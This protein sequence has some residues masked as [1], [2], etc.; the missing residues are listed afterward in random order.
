M[1]IQEK[2][3]KQ[4]QTTAQWYGSYK[5]L[6][7]TLKKKKCKVVMFTMFTNV[8][9]FTNEAEKK[10]NLLNFLQILDKP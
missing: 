10:K 4:K 8:H 5:E 3:C 7:V 6:A 1:H 9:M 2:I